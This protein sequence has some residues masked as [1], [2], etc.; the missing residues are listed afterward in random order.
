MTDANYGSFFP[1][2]R[3]LFGGESVNDQECYDM[4]TEARRLHDEVTALREAGARA[5]ARAMQNNRHAFEIADL[6]RERSER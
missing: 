1:L 5:A 2:R 4:L 3:Q 6:M